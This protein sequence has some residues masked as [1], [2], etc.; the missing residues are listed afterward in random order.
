MILFSNSSTNLPKTRI[1]QLYSTF[2][3][4][5][6]NSF[7]A[8]LLFLTMH[9]QQFFRIDSF[10]LQFPV[11]VSHHSSRGTISTE[12]FYFFPFISSLFA[13]RASH[14]G[15]LKYCT[16]HKTPL[17]QTEIWGKNKSN[18]IKQY[19]IKYAFARNYS[20]LQIKFNHF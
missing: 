5:L 19:F 7:T 1:P 14:F 18:Q 12:L 20:H 11:I 9:M 15:S 13:S 8:Q 10:V 2:Q 4:F 17:E 6:P 16:S 3:V